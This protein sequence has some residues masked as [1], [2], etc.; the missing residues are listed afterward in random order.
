MLRLFGIFS[1]CQTQL[2]DHPKKSKQYRREAEQL[3]TSMI[4][5]RGGGYGGEVGN[6]KEGMALGR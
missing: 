2:I 6:E 3:E 1:C 4:P 5:A